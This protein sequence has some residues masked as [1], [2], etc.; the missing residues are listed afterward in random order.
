MFRTLL[1]SILALVSLSVAADGHSGIAYSDSIK[2]AYADSVLT[3]QLQADQLTD[4]TLTDRLYHHFYRGMS[5]LYTSADRQAILDEFITCMHLDSTAAHPDIYSAS[6]Y[7]ASQLMQSV[8][9]YNEAYYF[10]NLAHNTNPRNTTYLED[11]AWFEYSI[12]HYKQAVAYFLKLNKLSPATPDYIHGLAKAYQ[13]AGQYKKALKEIDRYTRLE[14]HSLPMLS[15]RSEIWLAAG[16]PEK[17]IA[18]INDYIAD[19]PAER[20]EARYMLAQFNLM[21]G[22]NDEALAVLNE[23]NETYPGNSTILLALADFHKKAGNDSL[24][25]RCIFDAIHTRTIPAASIPTIIRPVISAAIQELDTAAAAGITEVLNQIYPSQL[26]ILKLSADTYQALADTANWLATLYKISPLA[27]D[28]TT[29]I[30][31][32]DLE[33]DRRNHPQVRRLTA[34]GYRRHAK[35]NWAYFRLISYGVDEMYDS[36]LSV[37][38]SVIPAVTDR[39][40][41][42]LIFQ[43]VGDTHSTLG[44]D[45]IAMAMYDSCLVYNP[46]NAGAL[47]NKAYNITKHP[48]GDLH[49]AER[50]ASK[51]LEIE[52][53]NASTLDTYAWILYLRGDYTLSQIYFD[54]L[55][56]IEQEQGI[57]SGVEVLYHR[58]MLCMKLNDLKCTAQLFEEALRRHQTDYTGKGKTISEPDI[59][60]RMTEWLATYKQ[61]IE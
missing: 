54:K 47:N 11:L 58:G 25:T 48:G 52:P 28:E 23:L 22:R 42:S 44:N 3:A 4:S 59:I 17:A 37:A 5:L 35:D 39:H 27:N 41:R 31:I 16:Q 45:S 21:I 50:L 20:L 15:E 34:D 10:L 2:T 6:A 24:Q 53:E 55:R 26:P 49:L 38:D 56:R 18:E 61:L 14:G 8:K 40:I 1:I 7:R 46:K 12:E 29:D 33:L 19:N 60:T 13:Q 57:G 43:I 9:S 36:L 51:A 30:Q 32:I